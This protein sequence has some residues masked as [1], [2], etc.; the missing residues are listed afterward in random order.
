VTL[1]ISVS[2][3]MCQFCLQPDEIAYQPYP[4]TGFRQYAW[5]DVS[6]VTLT[7]RYSRGR[8][9][10][11]REQFILEMRDGAALDLMTW[12]TAAVHAFPSNAQALQGQE[13]RFDAAGVARGCP[14]PY[15]GMLSQR[16]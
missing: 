11:W 4:W 1:P 9:Y 15:L 10:G 6:A 7:C 14:E 13:F 2:A 3:S 16:P 12:P 8:Y 5:Q